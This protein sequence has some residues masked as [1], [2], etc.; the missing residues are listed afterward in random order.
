MLSRKIFIGKTLHQSK[1]CISNIVKRTDNEKATLTINKVNE[2]LS[3]LQLDIVG[4]LNINATGLNRGR[5]HLN[6]TGMGKLTS[7]FH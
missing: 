7:K 2:H 3:G 6:E 4:N 5:L 1:V